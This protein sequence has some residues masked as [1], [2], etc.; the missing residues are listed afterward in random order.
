LAILGNSTLSPS[1]EI[2]VS[3][4]LASVVIA[5]IASARVGVVVGELRMGASCIVGLVE[6]GEGV[7]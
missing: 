7:E 2:E 1:V 6:I 4:N 3:A 5:R